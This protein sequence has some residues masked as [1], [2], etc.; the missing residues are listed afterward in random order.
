[1]AA[2]F[3]LEMETEEAEALQGPIGEPGMHGSRR[4]E[5]LDT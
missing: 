4:F 3:N 5:S 1:M 2:Y